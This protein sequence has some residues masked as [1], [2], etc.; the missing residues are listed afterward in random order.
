M[1]FDFKTILSRPELHGVI[2]RNHWPNYNKCV[3]FLKNASLYEEVGI[4][5][6]GGHNVWI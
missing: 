1:L 2:K 5:P 4:I 6:P 3:T